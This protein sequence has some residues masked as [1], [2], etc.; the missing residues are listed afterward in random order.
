MTIKLKPINVYREFE[1]YDVDVDNRPLLDIQDNI[2]E[3]VSLLQTSG[4]YSEIAADPSQ[5]P[6]GGF[7]PFTCACVYSNS[8][9]VPID[10]SKPIYE[11]DYTKYPIILILGYNTDTQTYQ[12]LSFSAGMSLTNKFTSFVP[13]SEGRLL[14]VGPG[15][16]LV[17]QLYYDL[18]Y[19]SS[20]YQSLYV[21]KILNSNSIVFGGNQVSILGNN[22]Y[23]AKNRDDLT[24]GLVTIQ[25]NNSVSNTVFNA[26]S[27]NDVGSSYT[28]AEYVNSYS[29]ANSTTS[30]YSVPIYFSSYPLDFD[31]ST[32]LFTTT[33]LENSLNEVHFSTP[34]V[35]T[36]S[37]ASQTYLTAGVN[38]RSLLDFASLNLLHAPSYS[39]SITETVQGI[40]TKLAFVDRVKANPND[41]DIPIGVQVVSGPSVNVG[42]SISPITNQPAALIPSVETTGVVLGDFFNTAGAYIGGVQD[43]GGYTNGSFART[44]T[45]AQDAINQTNSG[46]GNGTTTNIVN[47]STGTFATSGIHDYDNSFVLLISTQSNTSSPSHIAISTDGYLTLAG[48]KG[49]LVNKLPVLDTEIAPKIY[50]DNQIFTIA[51]SSNAKIPI[52]GTTNQDPDTLQLITKPV[53]GSLSFDVVGNS[54][55]TSQV[56]S[57]NST[58]SAD[59]LSTAPINFFKTNGNLDYQLVRGGTTTWNNTT[60]ISDN[61]AGNY[62]YVNKD[63]L[64]Q[65][66]GYA[67]NTVS[68][69]MP[70][71]LQGPVILG[72]AVPTDNNIVTVD[73]VQFQF[74][75]VV[76][77]PSISLQVIGGTPINLTVGANTTDISTLT[78]ESAQAVLLARGSDPSDPD[79]SI[80]TKKYVD[81]AA[82]AATY[83]APVPCYAIW[84]DVFDN[85]Y[86]NIGTTIVGPQG[87]A[88]TIACPFSTSGADAGVEAAGGIELNFGQFFQP[89]SAGLKYIGTT[90]SIFQVNVGV[91]WQ[92][93]VTKHGGFVT[94][95]VL[96]NGITQGI[97][98]NLSTS[99]YTS[100]YHP[101]ASVSTLVPLKNG[102]ILIAGGVM[103]GEVSPSTAINRYMSILKVG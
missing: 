101:G 38:V 30:S 56:L 67:L 37:D 43:N 70:L 36:F 91:T 96:V 79:L 81:D 53:T 90:P 65:Y 17:D 27:I 80:P 28:Y 71:A 45:V 102:D 48:G 19:A 73:N 41:P 26:V 44:V 75:S 59:I 29:L 7:T 23:L 64:N 34:A 98:Y 15:G 83:A 99:A 11:I 3:I 42:N 85:S 93:N 32:G 103:D 5:E 69:Y 51:T 94:A 31:Q 84:P 20:G 89:S 9:L 68:G 47:F 33:V 88:R 24:S 40:S 1:P 76:G 54:N 86:A 21:G 25:R 58:N 10:I 8:L 57:F 49:T 60:G 4:F 52:T 6:A 95:V 97:I 12:C 82:G 39:N 78:I 50:V 62:E 72:N 35:T 18:S 16:T 61:L 92:Q 63:F 100:S 77:N 13:G 14:K 87:G 66:T 74:I 46:I 2:N 22:F 55:S